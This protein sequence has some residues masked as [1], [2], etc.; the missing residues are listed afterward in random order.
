MEYKTT[1]FSLDKECIEL[2]AEIAQREAD[3]NEKPNTSKT[4]RKMIREKSVEM[5]IELKPTQTKTKSK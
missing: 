3:N 1:T 2:L 5:G 4:L